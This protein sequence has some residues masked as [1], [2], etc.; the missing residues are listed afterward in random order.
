M[1]ITQF[2]QHFDIF[3]QRVGLTFQQKEAYKTALG[4]TASLVIFVLI[5]IYL[6]LMISEPLS[7]V[8]SADL[9]SFDPAMG[10]MND[11][12]QTS[13]GQSITS[14]RM[15][16]T[17]LSLDDVNL[18][19]VG[20]A[21]VNEYEMYHNAVL[22][23]TPFNLT[24]YSFMFAAGFRYNPIDINTMYLEFWLDIV[25]ENGTRIFEYVDIL[26]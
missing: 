12:S 2:L 7:T 18:N 17:N 24:Q 19:I 4:G 21:A 25:Y 1:G 6:Y 8:G 16:A 20:K 10:E 23:K 5:T 13:Q 22:D 3:S 15:R 14:M 26:Q 11:T 9:F